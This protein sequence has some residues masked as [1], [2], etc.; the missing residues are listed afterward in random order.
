MA[1]KKTRNEELIDE[2]LTDCGDPESFLSA[3]GPMQLLQKR[4]YEKALEAEMDMHLGYT[5]HARSGEKAVNNSRNGFG[6]KTLHTDSGSLEIATPRDRNGS[7]TP[8]IVPKRQKNVGSFKD[9]IIA[10]YSRGMSVRDIQS[11]LEEMYWVDV[12]EGF[13]STVTDSILEDVRQWQSRPLDA[14]YPIVFLD[15][16]HL[17]SREDGSVKTK[18]VYLAL[19][20]NM[21]GEKELLGM[22]IAENEGSK[23]WLSVITE[24]QNRGVNDIFIACVD[25]LKGFPEAIRSVYPQTQ[26]QLCIVH[27][28]RNSV[29]Y[30]SHKDRK[31]LCGDLRRIYTASTLEQAELALSEFE[32]KWDDRYRAVSQL[33]RRNWENITPFFEYPPPIRKVM[34]TTNA[35]ESLNRSL[36]KVLKTKGCFPTDESIFKLMYLALDKISKKWTMPIRDWKA[37][38]NQ[39]A[40]KFEGRFPK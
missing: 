39:F 18:V 21:Q 36:R 35:I 15:G 6:S 12:S 16:I 1:K 8:E 37:A 3:D 7:F 26:V 27:M 11:N 32:Q 22:W 33:W 14:V 28:V 38:L 13:I 29:K 20:I 5:K 19:G 24:L 2:L 10:L 23:F 31:E 40:I 30:V 4:F 17:K 25:G 9:K 34:Y